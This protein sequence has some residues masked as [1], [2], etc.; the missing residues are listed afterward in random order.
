MSC[1]LFRL[2]HFGL[3]VIETKDFSHPPEK[4]SS[5]RKFKAVNYFE[6]LESTA[7]FLHHAQVHKNIAVYGD[8]LVHFSSCVCYFSNYC[9]QI[10]FKH[11]LMEDRLLW[12]T[13]HCGRE[14]TV[15]AAALSTARGSC[16][17]TCTHL[18]VW[19]GR[20]LRSEWETDHLQGQ[21]RATH[22]CQPGHSLKGS[23]T[24]QNS[25]TACSPGIQASESMEALHD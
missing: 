24:S 19:G 23:P 11:N 18:G 15:A 3:C 22:F 6:N 2:E 25:I 9:N 4:F 13:V 10:P 12:L 7:K 17:L 16:P 5:Y 1:C 21:L 20:E 14:D 8:D